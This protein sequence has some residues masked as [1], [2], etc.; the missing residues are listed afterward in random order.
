MSRFVRCFIVFGLALPAFAQRPV[1]HTES[2]QPLGAWHLQTGIGVEYLVKHQAPAPDLAE[3][4]FRTFVAHLSLGVANNVDFTLDWHGSLVATFPGGRKGYDWGDLFVATKITLLGGTEHV[5]IVGFRTIVK[6]PNTSYLPL[7]LGSDITD[8]YFQA[9]LSTKLG[10]FE[11]R[12]NIGFGIIGSPTSIGVQDDILSISAACVARFADGA[13]AFVEMTG[14]KGYVQGDGKLVARAGAAAQWL[15]V[16]WSVYGSVRAFG[17]N[18]DY[19]TA[20]DLSEDWS[21]GLFL[22]KSISW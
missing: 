10:S 3:K 6:L 14:V 13:S 18:R 9:L 11:P 17:N 21:V 7:K 15:D 22:T 8:F 12:L 19:A 1:M 5:P 4:I 20:F 16:E 2:A